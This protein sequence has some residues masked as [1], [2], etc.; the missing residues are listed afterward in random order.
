MPK[1]LVQILSFI[2]VLVAIAAVVFTLVQASRKSKYA[3]VILI[4]VIIEAVLLIGAGVWMYL[5][6]GFLSQLILV[7]VVCILPLMFLNLMALFINQ[8]IGTIFP[9]KQPVKTDNTKTLG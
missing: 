4:V 2:A 9:K 5:K 7:P 6:T 3:K 8:T 1:L